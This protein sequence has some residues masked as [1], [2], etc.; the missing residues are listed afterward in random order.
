M[1]RIG[2]P[3]CAAGMRRIGTAP[4]AWAETTPNEQ[5]ARLE[6]PGALTLEY[7]RAHD[8]AMS[9]FGYGIYIAPD[10]PRQR[11]L[12]VNRPA[13]AVATIEWRLGAA[14]Q[15]RMSESSFPH[16]PLIAV[17]NCPVC[18]TAVPRPR[19]PGRHRVYCTNACRQKAYRLRC[20][21]RQSHPMSAH[22]DPR[23]TRATSRDRVH[24]IREYADVSSGR[25]DSTGRGIT[26][27]GTFARM[28]IDTPARFGHLRFV[29]FGGPAS[30]TTCRRCTQLAG[31][32]P[33]TTT[34]SAAPSVEKRQ[35]RAWAA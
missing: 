17:W 21:S 30:P 23:P 8:G 25:R 2:T 15:L 33:P 5:I 11:T 29:A 12:D 19:R 7:P 26:A 16:T 28:S 32:A 20:Q 4:S 22:R 3:P 13:V 24:A 6:R 10:P 18:N 9:R 1:R 35:P 27:C 14:A 34:P 31:S